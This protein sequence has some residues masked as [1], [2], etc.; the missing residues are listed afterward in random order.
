MTEPVSY[1]V[2]MNKN[3]SWERIILD[4]LVSKNI[5]FGTETDRAKCLV[6]RALFSLFAL[7]SLSFNQSLVY[8]II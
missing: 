2:T 3:Q 4:I 7:R 5:F 8:D 1:F 6:V